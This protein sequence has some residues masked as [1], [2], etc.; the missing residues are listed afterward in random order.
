MVRQ[1][2]CGAWVL[3]TIASVRRSEALAQRSSVEARPCIAWAKRS[4][5]EALYG[6][7]TARHCE[8]PVWLS[9]AEVW[10]RCAVVLHSGGI[11]WFR[12]GTARRSVGNAQYR[13][14]DV[15]HGMGVVW[16]G[17]GEAWYRLGPAEPGDGVAMHCVGAAT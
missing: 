11:V 7:V 9:T 6:I 17:E 15:L 4:Y 3:R 13:V 12:V 5:P 1:W 8:A 10:R 14:G 16:H 2:Y